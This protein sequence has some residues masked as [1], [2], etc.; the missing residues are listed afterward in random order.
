MSAA[1]ASVTARAET[2]ASSFAPRNPPRHTPSAT[3]RSTERG[4]S[5]PEEID[6][7]AHRR[8]GQ[9]DGDCRGVCPLRGIPRRFLQKRHGKHSATPAQKSVHGARQCTAYN[10]PKPS[11]SALFFQLSPP[12]AGFPPYNRRTRNEP[13]V[14]SLRRFKKIFPFFPISHETACLSARFILE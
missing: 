14:K 9:N 8:S 11:R 12:L 3:G 1:N 2:R 7:A 5:P 13:F 10:Q 4:T 6:G